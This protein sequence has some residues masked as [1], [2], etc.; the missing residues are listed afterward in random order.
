MITLITTTYNRPHLLLQCALSVACSTVPPTWLIYVDD[1][2][3]RYQSTLA[4]ISKLVANVQ[5]IGGNRVGRTTA[6]KIA[7]SKVKTKWVGWLDDDDWLDH[8]CIEYCLGAN[9]PFV[10]T[11]F[12]EV[13]G[14]KC[15]V[16]SRN[17]HEYSYQL[18]LKNNILFH[19]RLFHNQLYHRCG[20]IDDSL[21]TTMD[22]DLAIRLAQLATPYKINKPL[23][24]YRLHG[25]R[26]TV[27]QRERQLENAIKIRAKYA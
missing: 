14:N 26:I 18:L 17:Q 13:S 6:L 20:G 2:F 1:Q 5:I 8:R 21:D 22:Y 15:R 24:Y 7:H 19:F 10:Y 27:K 23:Y 11:D 16:S 3:S 12:Y 25:N 4:I 9:R